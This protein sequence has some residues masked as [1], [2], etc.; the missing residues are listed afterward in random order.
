MFSQLSP[1]NKS[2]L[3]SVAIIVISILCTAISSPVAQPLIDSI[4]REIE[5]AFSDGRIDLGSWQFYAYIIWSGIVAQINARRK[6][7]VSDDQP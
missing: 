7:V 1:A 5:K 3:K 2:S 4:L 6:P